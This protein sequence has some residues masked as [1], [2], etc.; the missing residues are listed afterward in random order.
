MAYSEASAVGKRRGETLVSNTGQC[1]S[2]SEATAQPM[3][4][5]GM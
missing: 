3:A 2:F 1:C 4:L 5:V